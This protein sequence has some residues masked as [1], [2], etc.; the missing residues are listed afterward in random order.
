MKKLIKLIFLEASFLKKTLAVI[1]VILTAFTSAFLAVVSVLLDTPAGVIAGID[2]YKKYNFD[3]YGGESLAVCL[4]DENIN[5]ATKYDAEICYADI[6]GRT[7]EAVFTSE[8]GKFETDVVTQLGNDPDMQYRV[9]RHGY[10]ADMRYADK[11]QA[12]V[13]FDGSREG[14]LLSSDVADA[15]SVQVGDSVTSDKQYAVLGIYKRSNVSHKYGADE[16]VIPASYF[17]IVEKD[18][19]VVCN[20]VYIGYSSAKDLIALCN[21]LDKQ[22]AP[23]LISDFLS[24]NRENLALIRSFYGYLALLLGLMLLFVLYALFSLFFRERKGQM[25]RFGLL[26]ATNAVI[27][28]I[29]CTIAVLAVVLSVAIASGFSVLLSKYLL[30]I[31]TRVFG[32]QYAY[33]FRAWLPFSVAGAGILIAVA[34]FAVLAWRISRVP[35]AEEVRYE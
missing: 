5:C 34:M 27:A 6:S 7:S 13:K 8:K 11:L 12:L 23:Y 3:T 1:F 31:C 2:K 19:D 32:S 33:H 26:G 17:Y 22:G 28:T 35:I 9:E 30:G 29:Y 18:L 14:I 4:V 10:I 15:L 20:K 16:V 21:R 25:C 24:T